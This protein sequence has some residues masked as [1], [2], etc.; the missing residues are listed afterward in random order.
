MV[1]RNPYTP[2]SALAKRTIQQHTT[3][4]E[5][6]LVREW[7]QDTAP[8]VP[9]IPTSGAAYRALT[10]HRV[11]HARRGGG[12]LGAGAQSFV[13]AL[14]P[15]AEHRRG[16]GGALDADDA[17]AEKALA[18]TL[19][20]YLRAGKYDEA[21]ALCRAAG[22]D[23]RAAVIGGITA[24]KWDAI[25]KHLFLPFELRCLGCWSQWTR[26]KQRTKTAW[27][28]SNLKTGL[29]TNDANCGKTCVSVRL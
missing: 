26:K 12:A 13:S 20:A 22:H 1:Q 7:L 6:Y 14:D 15:D 19:L 28:L 21:R 11:V 4:R 25:C 10:K 27:I 29:A 16:A 9:S 17:A 24:L 8:N 3:L 18:R 5:L 23:W 2:T